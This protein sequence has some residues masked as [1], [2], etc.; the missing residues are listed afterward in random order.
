MTIFE[1]N[2][3]QQVLV[4]MRVEFASVGSIYSSNSDSRVDPPSAPS[5]F[6]PLGEGG[7]SRLHPPCRQV[8]HIPSSYGVAAINA[9]VGTSDIAAGVGEQ[10]YHWAHEIRGA[11]HLSLGN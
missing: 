1:S 11:A 3:L 8:H 9:Q 2:R 7:F 4:N 10:K 5:L 6:F